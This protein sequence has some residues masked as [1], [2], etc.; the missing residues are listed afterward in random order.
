MLERQDIEQF[1]ADKQELQLVVEV[2]FEDMMA[3]FKLAA[4]LA[5]PRG[6]TRAF[7]ETAAA[8]ALKAVA[9]DAQKLGAGLAS[10]AGQ[11]G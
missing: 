8:R 9:P 6:Y 11:N 2:L 10:K 1:T 5:D 3:D 4:F 7:M